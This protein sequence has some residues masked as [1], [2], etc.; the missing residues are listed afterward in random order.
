[1]LARE[2]NRS[3]FYVMKSRRK[4]FELPIVTFSTR[5]GDHLISWFN[6]ALIVLLMA[7]MMMMAL[8]TTTALY[9]SGSSIEL[10]Q[11]TL[12]NKEAQVIA[13]QRELDQKTQQVAAY[14]ETVKAL[15]VKVN[16][17]LESLAGKVNVTLSAVKDTD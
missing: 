3:H 11:K 7:V 10:Y 1:M 9:K 12:V 8:W 13:L 17:S 15:E 16:T 5:Q 2:I 6:I 4:R 14:S